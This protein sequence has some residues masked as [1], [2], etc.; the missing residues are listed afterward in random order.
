MTPVVLGHNW[1]QTHNLCINWSKG[2]LDLPN[3]GLG[4]TKVTKEHS[5]NKVKKLPGDLQSWPSISL[6]NAIAYQCTCKTLGAQRFQLTHTGLSGQAAQTKTA[7]YE[8]NKVPPVYHQFV[9]VFD[10]QCSRLLPSHCSY[11]L[12]IQLEEGMVPPIGLIYSLSTLELQTLREFTKENIKIGTICVRLAKI[13]GWNEANCP[14]SQCW[15]REFDG[16]SR[17]IVPYLYT[18]LSIYWH[19]SMHM[20]VASVLSHLV[21]RPR[22]LSGN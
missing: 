19:L 18:R 21:V 5:I 15:Q 10:K 13:L 22:L 8:L 20:T 7:T 11:D 4:N 3:Q 16:S 14:L 6:I 9:D 1:L 17:Y 2:T 12:T